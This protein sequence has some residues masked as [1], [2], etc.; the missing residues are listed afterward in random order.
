M[1]SEDQFMQS[2]GSGHVYKL[3]PKDHVH[4]NLWGHTKDEYCPIFDESYDQGPPDDSTNNNGSSN[5]DGNDGG[6][7]NNEN[8]NSNGGASNNDG[9]NDNNNDG[10]G[11]DDDNSDKPN[12]DGV[13]DDTMDYEEEEEKAE[14]TKDK[15]DVGSTKDE[16]VMF[17]TPPS[18]YN[19][20]TSLEETPKRKWHSTSFME[21]NKTGDVARVAK[22]AR[23]DKVSSEQGPNGSNDAVKLVAKIGEHSPRYSEEEMSVESTDQSREGLQVE[24]IDRSSGEHAESENLFGN[25]GGLPKPSPT[26]VIIY[27][28]ISEEATSQSNS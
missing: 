12:D 4:P 6:A 22:I 27:L 13:K 15:E 7:D 1:G 11:S 3:Q 28:T 10:T 5:D 16:T 25:D 26:S 17:H 19:D 14:G 23:G 18:D 9:N 8:N 20:D 2:K 24:T 21:R